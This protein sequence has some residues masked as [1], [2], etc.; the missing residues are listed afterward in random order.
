MNTITT[1]VWLAVRIPGKLYV[2]RKSLSDTPN[3]AK[4]HQNGP[5]TTSRTNK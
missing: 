1:D 3:A 4:D 5:R 2:G